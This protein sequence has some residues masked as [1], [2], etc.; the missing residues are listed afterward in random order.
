MKSYLLPLTAVAGTVITLGLTAI[1]L[2]APADG[3]ESPAAAQ[4]RQMEQQSHLREWSQGLGI[5][6]SGGGTMFAQA[7]PERNVASVS[8]PASGIAASDKLPKNHDAHRD[9][10]KR[11]H[12]G[13]GEHEEDDADENRS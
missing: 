10:D 4:V 1:T 13:N 6:L 3:A 11:D 2:A 8:T 7:E 12:A 9:H 5:D